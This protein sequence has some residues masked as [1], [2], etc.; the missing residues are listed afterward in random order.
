MAVTGMDGGAVESLV[1]LYRYIDA[2]LKW[3]VRLAMVMVYIAGI[4][5]SAQAVLRGCTL[6][7]ILALSFGAALRTLEYGRY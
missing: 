6:T 5:Y 3:K 7:L 4:S 2:E 1:N